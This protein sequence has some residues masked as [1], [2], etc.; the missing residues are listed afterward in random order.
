MTPIPHFARPAI[1]D[2]PEPRRL[3]AP[4]ARS[5]LASPHAG[6]RAVAPGLSP[7]SE[8]CR[9]GSCAGS[10]TRELKQGHSEDPTTYSLFQKDKSIKLTDAFSLSRRQRAEDIGPGASVSHVTRGRPEIGRRGRTIRGEPRRGRDPLR[11]ARDCRKPRS[12]WFSG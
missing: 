1:G 5:S 7:R 12:I 9:R 10:E 3:A 11:A 6:D 4:G 8:L 2:R